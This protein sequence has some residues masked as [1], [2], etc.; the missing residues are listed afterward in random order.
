MSDWAWCHFLCWKVAWMSEKWLWR[1]GCNW[2]RRPVRAVFWFF[3][4]FLWIK[5]G[6]SA[7]GKCASSSHFLLCLLM[8]AGAFNLIVDLF[9]GWQ[10]DWWSGGYSAFT[11]APAR[12][13]LARRE[14]A[15]NREGKMTDN[16]S[17]LM[18][19]LRTA[20]AAIAWIAGTTI[21]SSLIDWNALLPIY[22]VVHLGIFWI[23][24]CLNYVIF[25]WGIT[26]DFGKF[27]EI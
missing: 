22:S 17:L 3:Q 10:I 4:A 19:L 15:Q 11:V 9:A 6:W 20:H 7:I 24:A 16:T 26:D 21:S 2:W 25:Y 12:A 8:M 1:A 18:P 23:C 5:K 27:K 13:D 14:I